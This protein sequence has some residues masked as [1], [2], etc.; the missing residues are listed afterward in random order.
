VLTSSCAFLFHADH[1]GG[2][3]FK[4]WQFMSL[5]L[6]SSASHIALAEI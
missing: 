3:V 6:F 2:P 1:W 4:E 5:V